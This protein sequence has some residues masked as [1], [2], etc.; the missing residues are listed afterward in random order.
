MF[1][2]SSG[3]NSDSG[4]NSLPDS[5]INYL[6]GIGSVIEAVFSPESKSVLELK[7]KDSDEKSVPES[8]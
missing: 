6:I 7:S 3:A 4:D 1:R 8:P 2:I 5:G